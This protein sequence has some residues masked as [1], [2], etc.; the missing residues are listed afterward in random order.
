MNE[1]EKERE[2]FKKAIDSINKLLRNDS[3]T[4]ILL[5]IFKVPNVDE[6]KKKIKLIENSNYDPDLA[7]DLLDI[8]THFILSLCG[9]YLKSIIRQLLKA[10]K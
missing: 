6:L 9:I 10:Q 8:D 5:K 1:R 4:D 3:T 7:R 2:K